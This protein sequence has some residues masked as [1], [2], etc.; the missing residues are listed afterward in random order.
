MERLRKPDADEL[1]TRLPPSPEKGPAL[2]D[3][4]FP[5]PAEGIIV[6]HFVVATDAA[7]SA[8]FY[9]RVLGG[10]IVMEGPPS[11]V[12]LA[13]SWIIIN[14][15]GGPTDDKPEVV[16][17]VPDNP[18]PQP[19][20]STNP[21]PSPSRAVRVFGDRRRLH[22]TAVGR[23]RRSADHRRGHAAPPAHRPRGAHR[24]VR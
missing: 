5:A 21:R 8:D 16:L 14:E 22:R 15:G 24:G 1:P 23:T 7:V 9:T 10:T 18:P 17:H 4:E 2:P 12:K 20:R 6:T 11:I 3:M 13:N 19:Y